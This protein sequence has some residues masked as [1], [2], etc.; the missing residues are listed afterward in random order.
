[1]VRVRGRTSTRAGG[2]A[3]E[4]NKTSGPDSPFQLVGEGT[5]AAA[6]NAPACWHEV[7]VSCWSVPLGDTTTRMIAPGTLLLPVNTAC[8]GAKY[9]AAV[10]SWS[11][12][13]GRALSAATSN[14]AANH[15]QALRPPSCGIRSAAIPIQRSSALALGT[16]KT[17]TVAE[18]RGLR[19]SWTFSIS[20]NP[21]QAFRFHTERKIWAARR[22]PRFNRDCR[23]KADCDVTLQLIETLDRA[24]GWTR[25]KIAVFELSTCQQRPQCL[26]PSDVVYMGAYSC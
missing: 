19:A 4:A 26:Q 14:A 9:T 10:T 23:F 24:D 8:S 6:T 7:E 17:A 5:A 1:M 25:P 22:S 11:C 13:P 16:T 21:P 2:V 20:P 12:N 15:V 3:A 18:W